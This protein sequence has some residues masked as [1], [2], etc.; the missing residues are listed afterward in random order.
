MSE[1]IEAR[2][3]VD[4]RCRDGA[5]PRWN[6]HTRRIVWADRSCGRLWSCDANGGR[7][8]SRGLSAPVLAF[9]FAD[10]GR[11]LAGFEDGIG[12]LDPLRGTRTLFEPFTTDRPGGWFRDAALDAQGRL[13]L[14]GW[15][16]STPRLWCIDRGRLT[17]LP[18]ALPGVSALAVSSDGAELYVAGADPALVHRLRYDPLTGEP[19]DDVPAQPHARLPADT[20]AGGAALDRDGGLWVALTGTGTVQR[21][22]PDGTPDAQVRVPAPEVTGCV[23]GGAGLRELFVTTGSSASHDRRA[24]GAPG[25]GGLFVAQA[26]I[27]G[28]M[29]GTYRR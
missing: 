18:G 22:A 3:L 20:R 21:F 6:P 17:A 19:V 29:V 4:A 5:S 25:E 10:D 28:H 24:A 15:Q 1:A 11:V 26:P 13:L 16:D 14:S 12:W 2:L 8:K 7:P 9:G 27:A 23:F